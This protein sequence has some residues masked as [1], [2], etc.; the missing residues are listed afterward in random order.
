MTP[1]PSSQ[2]HTVI[3]E[4][5]CADCGWNVSHSAKDKIKLAASNHA[6][7]RRHLV[8]CYIDVRATY[9]WRPR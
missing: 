5:V 2:E 4:A 3:V 6:R 8:V 9:D 7:A 1:A